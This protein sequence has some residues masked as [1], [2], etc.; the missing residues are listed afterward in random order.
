MA[1]V[2]AGPESVGLPIETWTGRELAKWISQ[3]W[4]I[5]LRERQ[6]RRMLEA[7]KGVKARRKSK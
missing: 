5:R 3:R 4:S 2:T 6:C 1:A 7:A